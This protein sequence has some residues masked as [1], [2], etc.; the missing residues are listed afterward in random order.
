MSG[1]GRSTCKCNDKNKNKD[2]DE[3]KD[4]TDRYRSI[5]MKKMLVDF[6]LQYFYT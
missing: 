1:G 3:V 4:L 5:T 6:S 2:K